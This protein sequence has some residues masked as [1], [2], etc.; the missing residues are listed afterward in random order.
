ML[1]ESDRAMGLG[2]SAAENTNAMLAYW[3]KDLICRYANKAYLYWFGID[4]ENMIDK[5]HIKE[6]LGPLYELNLPYINTALNGKVCVFDRYIPLPN[7]QTKKARANYVPHIEDGEVKGF[8]VNVLDVSMISENRGV[9]TLNV[10][11]HTVSYLQPTSD[12]LLE[13]V[14]ETLKSH[15][16]DDFPGIELLAKKH[17]ISES[18]LKRDF[19]E[20]YGETIFGYYRHLQMELA[21]DYLT[22]KKANKG[23]LALMFNFSNPS[24]F[25]ACYRAYID[26][27]LAKQLAEK[28]DK[29][30]EY[31]Y[32]AIIEQ[33]PFPIAV[34]DTELRFLKASEKF[35]VGHKLQ[36]KDYIGKFLYDIWPEAKE[37]Y[38][39]ILE[40]GLKGEIHR[41]DGDWVKKTDGSCSGMRCDIRPW[42]KIDNTMGGILIYCD[43]SAPSDVPKEIDHENTLAV[44]NKAHKIA[45]IGAWERDFINGTNIW[46][47]V[48]KEIL[49]VPEDFDPS[50]EDTLVFYKDD[51]TRDMI[52]KLRKDSMENGTKFDIEVDMVTAKGNAIR[53]RAIGY[54]DIVNGKCE[55]VFG[56]FQDITKH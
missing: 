30:D 3:D 4:P 46:T 25:S 18:K 43:N 14:V 11:D 2:I 21:H 31:K 32:I 36:G 22:T 52:V 1:F 5:M 16:F 33:T 39:E 27:R 48:L 29:Q 47:S 37:L 41:A 20:K 24:N 19:K 15:I 55:R 53:V 54:P 28:L 45:R 34:L 35:I 23:Q 44:L 13:D 9:D 38:Q 26:D 42:Y 7:G 8:Y 40:K 51:S 50:L 49:E 12:H 6:L 17:Y 56:I 10:F